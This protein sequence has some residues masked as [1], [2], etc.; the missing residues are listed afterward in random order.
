[1]KKAALSWLCVAALTSGALPAAA[2]AGVFAPVKVSAA[3]PSENIIDLSKLL[4]YQSGTVAPPEGVT[5]AYGKWRNG[6]EFT[7]VIELTIS[8]DGTYKLIG[9]NCINDAYV[10]VKIIAAENCTVDIVCDDAF[11]KN[12]EGVASDNTGGY[13]YTGDYHNYVVPFKADAGAVLNISGKLYADTYADYDSTGDQKFLT[14]LSE[15]HHTGTVNCSSFN[16]YYNKYYDYEDAPGAGYYSADCNFALSGSTYDMHDY[17]KGYD[18]M[19]AYGGDVSNVSASIDID[20]KTSHDFGSDTECDYCGYNTHYTVTLNKKDGSEPVTVNVANGEVFSEPDEPTRTSCTFG[21]WY[22]DESFTTEYD[23]TKPV[24][25]NITLYAKWIVNVDLNELLSTHISGGSISL[26]GV[27]VSSDRDGYYYIGLNEAFYKI[28]G[29]NLVNGAYADVQLYTDY[30][31]SMNIEFDDAAIINRGCY[32]NSGYVDCF[33]PF[34]VYSDCELTVSGKLSIDTLSVYDGSSGEIWKINHGFGNL[35]Y[36]EGSFT[37]KY[38]DENGVTVDE[39]YYLSGYDYDVESP[40]YADNDM[41]KYTIDEEFVCI[42]PINGKVN[43]NTVVT[44]RKTHDDYD[45]S[46]DCE[47]CGT[48]LAEKVTFVTNGGGEY[49]PVFVLTGEKVSEPAEPSRDNYTFGGWYTDIDCTEKYDFNSAVTHDITLY[50]KWDKIIVDLPDKPSVSTPISDGNC[51]ILKWDPVEGAKSYCVFYR[52]KGSV[53]WRYYRNTTQTK[54]KITDLTGGKTYEFVIRAHNGST[55]SDYTDKDIITATASS[56]TRPAVTSAR[57]GVNCAAI[58]WDAVS[59]AKSYCVFYRERGAEHW[60]YRNTTQTSMKLTGLTGGKT[61][62]IVVRAFDG[63]S[64]TAYS[65]ENVVRVAV[66]S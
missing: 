47:N 8:Q 46:G 12:D 20:L 16:V 48:H 54:M 22:T 31:G 1:M 61:Y 17:I 57:G 55:W 6:D 28:K 33:A 49:D 45:N 36:K 19:R 50:A 42:S 34:N 60:K 41:N 21:G 51:I 2:P 30:T 44:V 10:D 59:G 26:P 32:L 5:A 9:S 23:F 65:Y 56:M 14:V 25:G 13:S 52:A 62:Q 27:S 7:G 58:K 64:W 43:S 24:S 15:K 3:D 39:N 11:I 66:K 38:V 4:D 35:I 18:C 63:S 53:K 29:S 37:V 40:V